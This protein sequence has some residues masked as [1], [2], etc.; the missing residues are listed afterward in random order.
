MDLV[1]EDP[2]VPDAP[3]FTKDA[4]DQYSLAPSVRELW[5]SLLSPTKNSSA[6]PCCDAQSGQRSATKDVAD[7]KDNRWDCMDIDTS[8]TDDV[9][10]GCKSTEKADVPFKKETDDVFPQPRLPFP[11]MSSLSSKDQSIY[12]G[13]LLSK[14]PQHPPQHLKSCVDHE[15]MQFQRYLQDV[16]KE[17]ADDYRFIPHGALQ[18]AEDYLR[19]CLECIQTLPQVYQISE[20]TSLTGGTFNPGLSLTFEKQLVVM[21]SMDITNLVIVPADAQLATD[22]QSVSSEN[23]PAKKAKDMHAA[24]SSDNNAEKLCARYEPHVCLTREALVTLL[25]NHGPDFAQRWEIP[26]CIRVNHGK[27]V[28]QKKTVYIESPLID[29]E[30]TVRRMSHIYHG[31]SLKLSI[32]KNGKKSMFHL[33]TELPLDD[34]DSTLEGS[35]REVVSL[36]ND[37]LDFEVDLTDLETFGEAQISKSTKRQKTPKKQLAHSQN[38]TTPPST[39]ATQLSEPVNRSSQEMTRLS[40]YLAKEQM[41]PSVKET[42]EAGVTN[43]AYESDKESDED[44]SVRGDSEDERLI[45]DDSTSPI[46]NAIPEPTSESAISALSSPKKTRAKRKASTSAKAPADP[47]GEILRMQ[48]AMFRR[49]NDAAT[50]SRALPQ[51]IVSPTRYVEQPRQTHPVSLVK[52]CVT[53][54]LERNRHKSEE[55]SAAPSVVQMS[56]PEK[57]KI[58]SQ[59]LQA[60]A[61]DEQDYIAPEKGNLL[62]KLY[63]LQDVLIIVR[64]S[65]PLAQKRKVV[66][67]TTEFVPV[68][69]LPKLNY[70][71]CHGVES[72]SSSEACH[73]WTEKALHSSTVSVVAHINAHT[74]KVALC[75]TLPE[76]WMQNI[77]CGFNPVKSLNILHHLLKKL[78]KM[79]AGQY[80]ITHK[81]GE[82]FVTLLKTADGKASRTAYDLRQVHSGLPQTPTSGSVPWIPVDPT[83]VM[84]FHKKH[85]R[86]PCTFPP[87][88]VTQPNGKKKKKKKSAKRKSYTRK[89]YT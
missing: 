76:T 35:K 70:Q 81:P 47:M 2:P 20:M 25:D 71:L 15:V 21:G 40:H 44:S 52:P 84:P 74:S 86:V 19:A 60:S 14:K 5:A 68:H 82:P 46:K 26:V 6:K 24:I 65:V 56:S 12:L 53:S 28:T 51:T 22:Y 55:T 85:G 79:E 54:Y 29:N 4:Y 61:E 42:N 11:C 89:S 33:M 67:N 32:K 9:P 88:T 34:H 69:V 63:S 75:R 77:S 73:L 83:V 87:H 39:Q 59:E 41:T 18:Y 1:W 80:L 62:Y 3:F 72:L 30:I 49:T 23:P 50:K 57:K 37:D 31:E 16:A 78:T 17:C 36:T 38:E 43:P 10:E 45:I 58:L 66:E 8:F 48:K 13:F 64:S 7:L 27:A